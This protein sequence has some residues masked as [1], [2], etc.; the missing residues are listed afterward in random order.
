[1]TE[2]EPASST[3]EPIEAVLIPPAA[4]ARET[5]E[6][7]EADSLTQ[8]LE[9]ALVL[10]VPADAAPPPVAVSDAGSRAWCLGID[11][12]TT[13][14]SAV[15]LDRLTCE[16][17]PIYWSEQQPGGAIEKSFR[18]P[19][20]VQLSGDGSALPI[21][22][23]IDSAASRQQATVMLHDFK[24][25]LK[26][27]VPHYSPQTSIWEPILQW[28]DQHSLALSTLHQALQTLLATLSA[29]RWHSIDA[30]DAAQLLSC[31]I[32]GAVGMN[33]QRFQ[34]VLQHLNQVIVGYPANWSDTYTLNLREAILGARLVA[35]P[36][37]ICFIEDAIA[38]VLS[39][40]RSS[41][42]R[43]VVLPNGLS[44]K[45][46]LHNADWQGGTLAISAGATVTELAIVNLPTSL[47]SLTYSD[48]T[49]RSLPY[50]GNAIDQDI[51]CQLLHSPRF[52][53]PRRAERRGTN[54]LN[55]YLAA[56]ESS[57]RSG[58]AWNWQA[59]D[60]DIEQATWNSLSLND[61]TLPLPGEPDLLNRQRLQQRLE[62]S[63]LGQSI[64]EAARHLKLIFQ[65]QD[66]F[67]LE[68]GDQ[69]WHLTRQDMG[70]RVILPYIQRL[71]RELN[72][73][74]AQTGM[75]MQAINQVVCTGG[76]A[77]LRAIAR[78]LRQKLPNATIIQDTYVSTRALSPQEHRPLT[79]SRIAYGLAT[80][81]LH[82][83][84]LDVPRQQYSDYFLLL[85][86]LRAFPDQP[87]TSGGVMQLLERRGIN[88]Q[89]CH[90][91]I[92]AL[93][94]GHLP[95]GLVPIERDA[96][97]LTSD[98][99]Q[100][101]EYAALLEAPLFNKRDQTYEPNY[102]QWSRFQQ[103]LN[104]LLATTHQTLTEPL[105]ASFV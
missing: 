49:I 101:P 88:T 57:E 59:T 10:A 11:I 93:L 86:L 105:L 9:A 75:P 68:L 17:F 46:S 36:D 26:V 38:A 40:L 87:L 19:T 103:Y 71:N 61:L 81:P 66:R 97:L 50:A 76:T 96:H 65:H 62:S 5:A 7:I 6:A 82:P 39:G 56:A 21:G 8:D 45:S 2:R 83:Q 33:A 16:L 28:S 42:D 69:Q 90:L 100:N 55:A 15:L 89:A 1:M 31:R 72:T 84:V 80:L 41:D 63:P 51:I 24:P 52:R 73:L 104:N 91:H 35:H 25:Y 64:L 53:Q 60:P 77:S 79:C 34:R 58:E 30:A 48:F 18:L 4:P 70:S 13:G 92:L 43:A 74:L 98:S 14:I 47:A 32:C 95:P 29:Q 102:V 78:W 37:Q 20:T 12:G 67:T 3:H 54:L 85:E 22:L 44:Q 23:A 94:E 99:R 27:A